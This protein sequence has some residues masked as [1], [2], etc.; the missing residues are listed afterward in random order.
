ML[1]YEA[2]T[3]HQPRQIKIEK[4]ALPSLGD[5]EVLIKVAF[6]GVCGTDIAIF[7]GEYAVSLPLVIG[8]EFTGEV[9]A[10]GHNVSD[11]LLGKHVTAEINN[12]CL[13]YNPSMKVN[14]ATPETLCP[15]CRGNLP[16]HCTRR[17]VV[18]I[19]DCD[20]AF[21][22]F[23]KAPAGNVHELPESISLQEGVF[24]EPLAAAIQTFLMTEIK[25]GDTVVVLGAGRLGVLVCAVA[26]FSG[27]KVVAVSRSE[28]KLARAKRFGAKETVNASTVELIKTIKAMTDGLGADVVVEST[29][30]PAGINQAL[31][32]A[33]PGGTIALKTTCGVPASGIDMTKLVVD[34]IRIQGS[35][36]GSFHQAIDVL[37]IKN[38]P[39]S[40]LITDVYPLKAVAEAIERAKRTSKV[41]IS[42][43]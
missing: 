10:V 16:N 7:E 42:L 38:I 30:T 19:I 6:A 36:C 39:V 28:D 31:D 8:H 32:L 40:S 23:I 13:S 24:I 11:A 17:T 14:A 9:S 5:N 35:R 22:Q 21:A 29:G 41:L 26:S 2:A 3:L 33:R 27:A 43:Q 25:K 20:G 18:G 34:E 37:K 15:A 1:M 12:T 4:R